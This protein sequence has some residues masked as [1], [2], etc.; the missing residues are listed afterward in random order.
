MAVDGALARARVL[1]DLGRYDDADPLLAQV[2]A[3]EPDNEE[4][5]SLLGYGLIQRFRW[6]EAEQAYT[7]LLQVNPDH[8]VGLI[9]MSIVL[10]S[11]PGRDRDRVRY[12]RRAVE[13]APDAPNA[14][15]NLA[16]TLNSITHG[17]A[18]AMALARRAVAIDPDYDWAHRVI[19]SIYLGVRRYAEAERATLEALRIDPLDWQSVLQLGLARAGLGRFAESR[20]QVQA[21]L[22]LNATPGVIDSVI[23]QIESRGLTDSFG[24]LYRM[25]LAAR[26]RPDLSYPGAAGDNPELLAAQAALAVRLTSNEAGPAGWQRARQLADAVLAKDRAS[27]DARYVRSMELSRTGHYR[28]ASS[29]AEKLLAEGYPDAYR[30]LFQAWTGL[31]H[32]T[33][34]LRLAREVLAAHPDDVLGLR[35]QSHCLRNLGRYAEALESARRAASLAPD[36]AGVQLELG[37]AAKGAGHL[38]LAEQ[39]FRAAM[40]SDGPR[41]AHELMKLQAW[42]P[43]PDQMRK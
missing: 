35:I 13:L 34:A 9:R 5:L 2:L 20:E 6:A 39:A 21:A 1:A 10:R 23:V 37:R 30:V 24:E 38:A 18:E 17:S 41:A 26:G 36:A 7:R 3:A 27:Q 12:A 8:L 28:K 11:V 32:Y 4:A 40:T 14:L 25:A 43:R 22:R 19:G 33:G 42:L 16:V 31:G 29:I 15:T